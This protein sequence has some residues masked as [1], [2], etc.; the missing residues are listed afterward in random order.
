MSHAALVIPGLDR[1]GGAERQ[2]IL[3]AKGLRGR[4]WRV[5]VVALS[6]TGGSAAGELAGAGA[7]FMS[8]GMRRGLA[9]PGGWIR[10]HRW[11]RRERPDVVHAHLPHAAWLAR[12]SRLLAPVP[13]QLDTLHSTSTGTAGRRLGY[14]LSNW[15]PDTVTAVS[16]AVADAHLAAGMVSP[17]KVRVVTNGVDPEVW[18][19]DGESRSA[20]RRELGLK[21]EFLWIAAGRL[22]PV[23]DY[24]ALLEAFASLPETARLSVAGGGAEIGALY[25]HAVNLGVARRVRFLGFVPD[26]Q[27]WMQ[28][29]DAFVL[30]SRW[31]G[32]PMALIEAACCG[33][34]AVCTDVGGVREIVL[35]GRT[36]FITPAGDRAALG[37]A[38]RQLME[39]PPEERRE[40]GEQARRI[41]I[42]RFSLSAAVDAWERLY[43][44]LLAEKQPAS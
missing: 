9:D 6:G 24:G 11:L 29:A 20:V 18:R 2:T 26:V 37:A 8:L 21:D 10:F 4:G 39:T 3:L 30:S 43:G 14:R 16:R 5:S 17:D 36:G 28:A 40:M 32:L 27:R 34:P 42:E 44:N 33:L 19:P 38:M 23:K 12:W 22:E 15:L 41:A 13:A 25:G 31:E 35:D 7:A 1:I